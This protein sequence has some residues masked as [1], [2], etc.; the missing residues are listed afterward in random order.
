MGKNKYG[1][2][3]KQFSFGHVKSARPGPANEDLEGQRGT[4]VEVRKGQPTNTAP[5][6]SQ[7]PILRE[8]PK[9]QGYLR[10]HSR[11][12]NKRPVSQRPSQ[13]V[14]AT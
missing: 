7:L 2:M 8:Q 13:T 6:P 11:G 9:D 12:S 1:V 4:S 5:S 10:N 3:K 14:T